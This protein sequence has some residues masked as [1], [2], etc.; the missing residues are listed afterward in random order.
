M[1]RGSRERHS[2]GRSRP[3][4]EIYCTIVAKE[5]GPGSGAGRPAR[6]TQCALDPLARTEV[7]HREWGGRGGCGQQS[8]MSGER[9]AVCAGRVWS[10]DARRALGGVLQRRTRWAR[11][12]GTN[13]A[14]SLL[15][16]GI[17][18]SRNLSSIAMNA[19][20]KRGASNLTAAEEHFDGPGPGSIFSAV[21]CSSEARLRH[22]NI[23]QYNEYTLVLRY[24]ILLCP[25]RA[26]D[27]QHSKEAAQGRGREAAQR[28]RQA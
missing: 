2:V 1:W 24:N 4:R 21:S 11:T 25:S 20:G 15:K 26:E 19:A 5:I 12:R 28:A 17:R 6:P 16:A 10:C 9:H 14:K 13:I 7:W 22:N 8:R 18:T 3:Q 27:E 23:S